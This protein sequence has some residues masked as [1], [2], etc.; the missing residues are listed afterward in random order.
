MKRNI[1]I[2]LC[3]FASFCQ[4]A[5]AQTVSELLQQKLAKFTIINADFTQQVINPVG[6]VIQKSTGKL[7]ISRPGNVHWQ[8]VSPDEELIVSNGKTMWL[9]SPFI[10]QVS[11]MN[12][13]DAV[14]DT[15]FVLLSGANK[16]QWADFNVKQFG[17]T[18]IISNKK[19]EAHSNKFT[20]VFDQT[21]N[22]KEFIVEEELGQKSIFKLKNKP[23]VALKKDLFEFKIPKGVEIDDQR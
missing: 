10:E 8:V 20:F 9:Y 14:A 3:V 1:I 6:K 13:S 19:A 23:I 4:F 15:A 5:S 16:K 2:T 21:D 7:T 17:D 12:F 18:F 22:I 11:I